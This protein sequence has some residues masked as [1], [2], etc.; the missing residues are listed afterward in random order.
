[1]SIRTN[2]FHVN[3]TGFSLIETLVAVS[4]LMLAV[5]GPLTIASKGLISAQFARDQIIAFHL[6]REATEL[7]RN[8]RDTNMLPDIA[9]PE[10]WLS[11][12][13]ACMAPSVCRVDGLSTS[14]SSC[15]GGVCPHLKK[16]NAGVYG[17]D[18]GWTNTPFVRSISITEIVPGVEIAA[19]VS[20]EWQTGF[21]NKEFTI[22]EHFFNWRQ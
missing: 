1:M 10:N 2:H 18:S 17:Y 13:E 5:V 21:L 20:V 11:G 22:T 16:N 3:H 9:V 14:F 4:V 8:T 6:A 7:I 19:N 15:P 12:M